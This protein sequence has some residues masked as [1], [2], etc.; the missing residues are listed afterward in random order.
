M[1]PLPS[2]GI[3]R[4]LLLLRRGESVVYLSTLVAL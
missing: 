3:L 1:A 2:S 4:S